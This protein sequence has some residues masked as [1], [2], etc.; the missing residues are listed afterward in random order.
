MTRLS[1]TSGATSI[2]LFCGAGGDS[3]GFRRPDST[4]YSA[5]TTGRRRWRPTRPTSPTPNTCVSTLT[6]T[7]CGA[8]PKPASS[9]ALLSARKAAQRT[10]SPGPRPRRPPDSCPSWKRAR[11]GRGLGTHPGDRVRHPPGLRSPQLRCRGVRE[12]PALRDRLASVPLVAPRHGASWLPRTD[13]V[14]LR[15]PRRRGGN[16]HAPQWRDR[17]FSVFT[18]MTIRAPD[19]SIRPLA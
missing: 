17:I 3:D 9:S 1:A 8:C 2:H 14:C 12:R 10:V 4:W 5:P 11:G 18:R 16:E 7:T 15:R 13:R 6:T 19:L